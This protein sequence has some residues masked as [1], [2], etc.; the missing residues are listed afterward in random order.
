[1]RDAHRIIYWFTI[2]LVIDKAIINRKI[3]RKIKNFV[4]L[5]TESS[6]ILFDGRN[7]MSIAKLCAQRTKNKNKS[8]NKNKIIN[9][10]A[11][12]GFELAKYVSLIT[13]ISKT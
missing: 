2:S 5:E 8:E 1:M 7:N 4:L 12:L 9:T 3:K 6:F 10:K 13:F 11:I